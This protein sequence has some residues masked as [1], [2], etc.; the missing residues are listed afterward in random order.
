[1]LALTGRRLLWITD[2]ERESYSRYGSIASYAPFDAVRS[3]GLTSGR[4]GH[5]FQVNLNGGSAWRIPITAESRWDCKRV[6]EEFAAALEIQKGRNEASRT[7]LG[8][9]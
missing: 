5:I 7:E 3:I 8:R 4:S 1:L 6:A 9:R 2:R